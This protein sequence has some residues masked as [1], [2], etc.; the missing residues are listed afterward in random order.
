MARVILEPIGSPRDSFLP[1][2]ERDRNLDAINPLEALLAERREEV[3]GVETDRVEPLQALL[4][5]EAALGVAE[6]VEVRVSEGD[7]V[8]AES[9]R[10]EDLRGQRAGCDG[11]SECQRQA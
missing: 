10:R 8:I 5:A 9:V 1:D 11:R 4:A 2:Q 3:R 7:V 6:P